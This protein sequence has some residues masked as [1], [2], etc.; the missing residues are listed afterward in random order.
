MVLIVWKDIKQPKIG[1][2]HGSKDQSRKRQSESLVEVL[3]GKITTADRSERVHHERGHNTGSEL[4]PGG[5]TTSAG[6][7][8]SSSE[9]DA[10]KP[11]LKGSKQRMYIKVNG[12]DRTNQGT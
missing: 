8:G 11:Q 2:Q 1:L 6:N 12:K 10:S 5:L 4:E 3:S 7:Q 9:K